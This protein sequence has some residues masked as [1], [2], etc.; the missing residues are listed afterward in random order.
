MLSSHRALKF[1]L[2]IPLHPQYLIWTSTKGLLLALAIEHEH[3]DWPEEGL[4]LAR[5]E[6]STDF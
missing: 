6:S 3:K 1:S 2:K 4:R 5:F